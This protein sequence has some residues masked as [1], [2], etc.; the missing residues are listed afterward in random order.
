MQDSGFDLKIYSYS[1]NIPLFFIFYYNFE[2]QLN[3][4]F[5]V[6]DILKH[7][8]SDKNLQ[9]FNNSINRKRFRTI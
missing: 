4:K 2:F 5:T 1:L 3:I 9:K 7:I 6:F 8:I